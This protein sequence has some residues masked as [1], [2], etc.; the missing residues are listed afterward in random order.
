MS[1]THLLA[2]E[3]ARSWARGLLDRDNWAILDTETTGL[4]PT[5]QAIQIAIL[6]PNGTPLLDTLV[7]PIG[8]IPRDAT[9]IHGITDA[10]V[11]SAP[12]FLDI[13]PTLRDLVEGKTVIAYNAPFDERILRQT[14]DLHRAQVL[15]AEWE[16]AMRQYARFVGRWS[17]RAGGYAWQP[18]PR[19]PEYPGAKHQAIDDCQATLAVIRKMALGTER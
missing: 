18:L 16:C 7:R 8:R 1:V 13:Y 9:A 4:G 10:M 5:A 15:R 17:T 14:A 19:G 2:R 11:E 3:A 12:S 6:G